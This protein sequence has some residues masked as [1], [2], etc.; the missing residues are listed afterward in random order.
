[1]ERTI[2]NNLLIEDEEL[3]LS[4]RPQT[5][6][7]YIGQSKV[8]ESLEVFISAAKK[9]A[10]SLDH[11]LIYGPPG[12]GKTTLAHIIANEVGKNIRVTSGPAIERAGD[13]ASIITNLEEGDI[14]FID[15]IHRLNRVVEE[16]LYPALEDYCL[17]LVLGKGPA[18]KT[19][20]IDLPKFTLI[21]ATTRMGL[22]SSPLRERFGLSH[23]LDY[24]SPDEIAQIITRSAKI[25]NVNI[26]QDSI[27]ILSE[28]SRHTPRIANRLLKRVRDFAEVKN[29]GRVSN[30]SLQDALDMLEIDHLGLDKTDRKILLAIANK[31]NGGPVGVKTIAAATSEEI[32]TIED[33]CEPYLMQIGF[34]NRTP[35][36]RILTDLAYQHLG[37]NNNQPKG[38]F[39]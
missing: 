24:Y 14:L 5:L 34:I 36:G 11:V 31:F 22:I 17:D 15:E 37:L 4:L 23:H 26:D 21:G 1:M 25:I 18:A 12:L 2:L 8:K 13:L 29:A 33:V 35:K 10:E 7:E 27:K 19:M 38:L 20:R 39:P 3:D 6:K 28:R 9:R 16:M 30:N 32:D